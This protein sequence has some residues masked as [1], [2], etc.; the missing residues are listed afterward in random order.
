[1]TGA[2]SLKPYLKMRL[3]E[4]AGPEP[5]IPTDSSEIKCILMMNWF[6]MLPDSAFWLDD[7]T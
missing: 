1:M 6:E 3:Y 7:D 2:N 5:E 4:K